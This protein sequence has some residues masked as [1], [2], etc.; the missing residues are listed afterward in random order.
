MNRGA[1]NCVGDNQQWWEGHCCQSDVA[2]RS[3][4]QHLFAKTKER[5]GQVD[6]LVNNAGVSSFG[7]LESVTE[8]EFDRLFHTNVLGVLLASQEALKHFGPEGG[9]IINIGSAGTQA[10]NPGTVVY[11]ATKGALDSITHVLAKELAS[12]KIRVNAINPG[13]TETEGSMP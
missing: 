1:E 11:I 10:V 2:S 6:I 13:G 5:F 12:R 3:E 7:P 8:E 9:N 4:V